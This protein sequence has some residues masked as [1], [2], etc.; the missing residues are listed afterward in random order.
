MYLNMILECP[1]V[2]NQVVDYPQFGMTVMGHSFIE[3]K[4]FI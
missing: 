2:V 3:Y 4:S 1:I